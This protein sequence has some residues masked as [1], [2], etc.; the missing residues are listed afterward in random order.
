M[1]TDNSLLLVVQSM[2]RRHRLYRIQIKWTPGPP[3][4]GSTP[5]VSAE[6]IVAPVKVALPGFDEV[7]LG[8]GMSSNTSP[9]QPQLSHLEML[10]VV[11]QGVI[12]DSSFPTIMMVSSHLPEPPNPEFQ[13]SF[14]VIARWE[15]QSTQSTLHQQFDQLDSKVKKGSV[16]KLVCNNSTSNFAALTFWQQEPVLKR[17]EDI[18]VDKIVLSVQLIGAGASV[19]IFYSDSSIEFRDRVSFSII[20]TEVDSNKVTSLAQSGFTFPADESCMY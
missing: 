11:S 13:E 6:L 2:S 19:A 17:L 16:N 20:S 18:V 8:H 3:V 15:L 10:P 5:S 14:S 12:N 1:G 7:G 4:H 9:V